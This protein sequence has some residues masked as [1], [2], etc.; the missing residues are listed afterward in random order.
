MHFGSSASSRTARPTR[1]TRGRLLTTLALTATMV[2]LLTLAPVPSAEAAQSTVRVRVGLH[3]GFNRMVFDWREKVAYRVVEGAGEATIYF[4]TPAKMDLT[5]YRKQPLPLFKSVEWKPAKGGTS[6][7][8]SV[9]KGSRLKH[10]RL[11][12]RVVIDVYA[13]TVQAKAESKTMMEPPEPVSPAAAATS[14]LAG[15]QMSSNSSGLRQPS[16]P[17]PAAPKQAVDV[18]GSEQAA[19][20]RRMAQTEETK[21]KPEP[22]KRTRKKRSRSDSTT[23][24]VTV[25]GNVSTLGLGGEIGYRFNDFLGVRVGGNYFKYDFDEDYSGIEYGAEIDLF[26][27]GGVIDLYPFGGGFRLTGGVRY[28]GNGFA[29]KA[30]PTVNTDIGGTTYTPADIGTLK[31]D[32]DFWT[33]APYAGL[34]VEWGMFGGHLRMAFDA[35]VFYQGSPQVD[36]SN[37]GILAG[38]PTFEADLKREADSLEDDLSILNF[39]PVVGFTVTYRF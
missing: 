18:P 6:V 25:G 21:P 27:A 2:G 28:N 34:G 17:A 20:P 5:S 37:N 4:D 26:S 32:I 11:R 39:Y 8:I 24:G 16:A 38:D 36:L 14:A 15:S 23:R 7:R 31:G 12:D 1:G 30:T 35:G 29:L 10:F 22:V 33:V 3:G 9:P 19:P 13:P